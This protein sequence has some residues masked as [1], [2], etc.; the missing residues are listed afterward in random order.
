MESAINAMRVQLDAASSQEE[1]E[2]VFQSIY[3]LQSELNQ[4]RA[5]HVKTN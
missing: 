5:R 2:V 4:L 1:K 3:V